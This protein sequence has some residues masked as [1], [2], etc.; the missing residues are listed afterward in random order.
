[1]GNA[2]LKDDDYPHHVEWGLQQTCLGDSGGGHWTF[3]TKE[4]RAT[5]IAI[6]TMSGLEDQWCSSPSV[7]TKLTHP[8]IQNW[9]KKHAKIK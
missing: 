9:I 7:V 5:L 1:M 3:N 2:Q 6:T 8:S 4:K